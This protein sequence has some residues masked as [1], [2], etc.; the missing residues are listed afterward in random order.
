MFKKII[1]L[2]LEPRTP[3]SKFSAI[4]IT[5]GYH[6][7]FSTISFFLSVCQRYLTNGHTKLSQGVVKYKINGLNLEAIMEELGALDIKGVLNY[8]YVKVHK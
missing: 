5:P 1:K 4:H 7:S 6:S 2:E 3:E 8:N